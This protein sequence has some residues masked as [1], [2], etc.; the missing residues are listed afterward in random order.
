MG[1]TGARFGQQDVRH[2]FQQGV[3]SGHR[4]ELACCA[5]G[6]AWED[7]RRWMR[8]PRDSRAVER[9]GTERPFSPTWWSLA[10]QQ[11]PELREKGQGRLGYVDLVRERLQSELIGS[12]RQKHHVVAQKIEA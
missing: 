9:L 8:R 7:E 2:H 3:L 10:A 6:D 4:L 5:L 11:V 12:R 1:L